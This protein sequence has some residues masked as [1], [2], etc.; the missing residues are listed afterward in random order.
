M[1][2][3]I[4]T[5]DKK[6]DFSE[7]LKK[8]VEKVQSRTE[9]IE[10]N[11]EDQILY[12]NLSIIYHIIVKRNLTTAETFVEEMIDLAKRVISPRNRKM[13]YSILST[14]NLNMTIE[15]IKTLINSV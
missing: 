9:D 14:Q 8:C 12:G 2:V 13:I 5:I 6:L 11:P 3:K 15:Y 7:I 10:K 1:L 4:I